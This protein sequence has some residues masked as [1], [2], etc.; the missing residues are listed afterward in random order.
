MA[1]PCTPQ[2]PAMALSTYQRECD[3]KR[4]NFRERAS[5]QKI[6]SLS[7]LFSIFTKVDKETREERK[8]VP[9]YIHLF[10]CL[11]GGEEGWP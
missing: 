3:G 11:W 10:A 9:V 5:Q 1:E 4:M 2:V 8:E 6:M 7:P